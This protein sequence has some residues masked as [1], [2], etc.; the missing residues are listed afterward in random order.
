MGG[1]TNTILHIDINSYFATMLQQENPYLRGKP[2]GVVK[3]VGRTCII[4]SSKEAKKF[5][6]GTGSLL[7][8]ARLVCPQIIT[9]PATFGRYLDATKR[10]Y[11]V[12]RQVAPEVTVYSLD[13][14]FID[15]TDCR[16][17]L[18]PDPQALGRQIQA[19]IK[20]ELGEWVT[21]NVGIS[22]NR[23][24]AKM[25]S[26]INGNNSV[27]VI[28]EQNLDAVLASVDFRK[29]CGIGYRL[30]KKLHS[31]G[32]TNPYLIRF[33]TETELASLVGPFWAGEL[34][35]IAYGKEPHHLE[36]LDQPRKHM[37]SVG[38]SITGYKL[39]D[40]EPTIQR[41]LY[42]LTEEVTHKARQMGLAGRHIGVYLYGGHTD[43]RSW[44]AHRTLQ[45][46]TQ[47]S[48]EMFEVLYHQLYQAWNRDFPVIKF[49]VRLGQLHP[50]DQLTPSLLPAWQR[51]QRLS[52]AQ[53]A[54][55][56][57]Y[58]LFTLRS[59]LLLRQP[60]VRPEVTGFLGDKEY[61]LG[62]T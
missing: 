40:D 39:V 62:W 51:R 41:V 14:A 46:H 35:K 54:V 15:I 6:V 21:C 59:G 29:V 44:Y 32:I 8:D 27:S 34:L 13:E 43:H 24:L 18:Y 37:A 42:N 17:H 25:A 31:W 19:M 45:Y 38:R 3:D 23:L 57:K 56:Q 16:Q 30:E 53:D 26:E 10:L 12:F 9:L 47:Q 1:M 11:Q 52:Q 60:I 33:H 4:A 48:T 55:A 61:Q 2:L 22:H 50:V 7:K 20:Q 49:G 28:N 36:L 58:G 5:G